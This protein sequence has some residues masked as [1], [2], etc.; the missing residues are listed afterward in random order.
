[1]TF[2]DW[3]TFKSAILILRD[4]EN[5]PHVLEKSGDDNSVNN[6][7]SSKEMVRISVTSPGSPSPSPNNDKSKPPG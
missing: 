5:K 6:N 1:M 7:I 4:S 3:E 2:G